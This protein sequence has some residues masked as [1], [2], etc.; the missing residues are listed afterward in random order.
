MASK[1]LFTDSSSSRKY[2]HVVPFDE[3]EKNQF[4]PPKTP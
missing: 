3:F 4:L 1:L 2:M